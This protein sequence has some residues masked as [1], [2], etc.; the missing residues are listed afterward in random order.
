MASL[1]LLGYVAPEAPRSLAAGAAVAARL[2]RRCQ[3]RALDAGGADLRGRFPRLAGHCPRD[4][5]AEAVRRSAPLVALAAG[6]AAQAG[7]CCGGRIEDAA[8]VRLRAAG[9]GVAVMGILVMAGAIGL[10][11]PHP[12]GI[13][14]VAVID[15]I[16]IAAL[17][18]AFRV[19]AGHV[20]AGACGCW[21]RTRSASRRRRVTS[22]GS[23]RA[24]NSRRRLLAPGR[25]RP[26]S[27][28]WSF[29]SQR[30]D[31]CGGALFNRRP[32]RTT[33]WRSPPRRS[34]SRSRPPA[35]LRSPVIRTG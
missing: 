25:G 28:S 7:C 29:C 10:A 13:V 32:G 30:P 21:S 6:P 23:R 31:S 8:L 17:A 27:A 4:R 5:P 3:R 26:S 24:I 16:V 34:A 12:A 35:A 9:S 14:P 18:Y 33:D 15:C 2:G 1:P 19:P 22:A 20:L 11:W